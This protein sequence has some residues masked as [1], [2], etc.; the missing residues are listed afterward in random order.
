MAEKLT[1]KLV[2]ALP[3]PPKSNRITYD[4]EV[5]GFGIRVTAAGARSFALNYRRKADALDRRWT[6]GSFPDWT[7]GAARD[8]ARR[9]KR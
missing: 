9:L 5:S 7:A 6:I 8:E 4:S 2:K 3:A 1:D